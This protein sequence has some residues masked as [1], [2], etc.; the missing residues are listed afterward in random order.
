MYIVAEW[1][2]A[3][4]GRS[5]CKQDLVPPSHSFTVDDRGAPPGGAR[6]LSRADGDAL[7]SRGRGEAGGDALPPKGRGE[8]GSDARSSRSSGETRKREG[9]SAD[10][11]WIGTC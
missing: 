6:R 7:P 3:N 5:Q 2:E 1:G 4:G 8:A 11:R 9:N 10:R